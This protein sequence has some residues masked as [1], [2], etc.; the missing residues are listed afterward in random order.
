MPGFALSSPFAL[1][2]GRVKRLVFWRMAMLLVLGSW[3]AGCAS[4]PSN[5]DRTRSTAFAAPEQTPLG[6]LAESRREQARTRSDSGFAL[7]DSVDVA[8][9]ARLALVD[10]AQRTLDLQYYAIHADGSTEVILQRL[11]AAAARG[12]RV[13]ILLDDFNTVGEDAQ[14]LRLAFDKGIEVRLFNPVPGSRGSLVGRVLGSLHDV[15]R[16]QKRMHNKLFIADS[17]WGITGGRN[18]GDAYFGGDEKSTFIDLDVLAAGAVVRQMSASFDRYW[19]DELS[20]P[21][22]SLLSERD[23]NR[24]REK[25]GGANRETKPTPQDGPVA[26]RGRQVLPEVTAGE[27]RAAQ[28]PAADLQ[29][30]PLT[31]APAALLVDRPGKIGPG[32]DE[33]NAG[34]TV[35]DGLLHLMQQ[36][37]MKSW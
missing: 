14:V 36:R 2:P 29:R 31:W 23:L 9:S 7:L 8:L 28:R 33:V 19:N 37:A 35:V 3:A 24:L 4:L 1:L 11:R 16:L 27:A 17:A 26:V 20:Y 34:D 10:R 5:V 30:I 25:D 22:Q 12:V 32:D 15:E 6:Q 18:L 13:R 21:V